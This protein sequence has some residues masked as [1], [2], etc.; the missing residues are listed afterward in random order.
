MLQP[1]S[2]KHAAWLN[3]LVSAETGN[4]SLSMRNNPEDTLLDYQMNVNLFGKVDSTSIVNWAMRKSGEDSNK[5]VKFVPNNKFYV[6]N[7]FKS[8]S[9]EKDAISLI[10]KIVSV[11]KYHDF[12]LK[13]IIYNSETLLQ[14]IA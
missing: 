9:N 13:K 1:M 6:D 11:L 12:N 4:M 2:T 8:I 7:Y 14:R 10:C 3:N 5:V